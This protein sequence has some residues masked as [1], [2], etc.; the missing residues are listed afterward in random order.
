MLLRSRR[1]LFALACAC[2][3]GMACAGGP[4]YG[5]ARKHRKSCDCPHWNAVPH[6]ANGEV[7]SSAQ[8]PLMKDGR[9]R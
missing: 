5:A 6:K 2:L 3:F 8:R 7:W 9:H 4:R 1:S